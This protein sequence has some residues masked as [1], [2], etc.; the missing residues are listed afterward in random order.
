[1]SS[2]DTARASALL[3]SA[4]RRM[5]EAQMRERGTLDSMMRRLRTDT[6]ASDAVRAIMQEQQRRTAQDA[7]ERQRQLE[8]Q[9]LAMRQMIDQLARQVESSRVASTSGSEA[10]LGR[11]GLALG[12]TPSCTRTRAPDGA[13]YW[14]YDEYPPIVALRTNGAASAAGLRVGDV[15]T[16][17]D[18]IS[19]L[20]AEGAQR[21]FRASAGN[22]LTL[23]VR[24]AGEE[25][26]VNMEVGPPRD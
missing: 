18:G 8:S 7:E 17:V 13:I 14:R 11:F 6:V 16:R 19:I 1:M 5:R 10:D 15:V 23:T 4:A 21:F 24:R 12:C 9:V 2:I 3:D 26:Q 20:S 22:R 25:R